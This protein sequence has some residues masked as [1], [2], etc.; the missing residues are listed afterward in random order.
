MIGAFEGIYLLLFVSDHQHLW[1]APIHNF[2]DGG[3]IQWCAILLF[4]EN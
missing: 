4:I 2:L 3:E 1:M